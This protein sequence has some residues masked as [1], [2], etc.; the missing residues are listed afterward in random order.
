MGFNTTVF[1]LNDRLDEIRRNPEK[2]VN[3]VFQ[4]LHEGNDAERAR[5]CY[6]TGQSTVMRTQHAD[7]PRLYIT[8]GNAILDLS[9][10]WSA[11]T[12]ILRYGDEEKRIRF[13]TQYY[14]DQIKEAKKMLREWEKNIKKFEEQEKVERCKHGVW[15][16]DECYKCYEAPENK[17][18]K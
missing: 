17:R 16:G 18:T 2:F 5:G 6:V 3:E 15:R 9:Y 13:M 8:H 11:K 1:L 7:V 10:P 4:A 12:E 14:K